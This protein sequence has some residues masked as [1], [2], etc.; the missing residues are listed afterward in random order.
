MTNWLLGLLLLTLATVAWA[1]YPH[2]QQDPASPPI[3]FWLLENAQ[4]TPVATWVPAEATPEAAPNTFHGVMTTP[5]Y[6]TRARAHNAAGYSDRS[7]PWPTPT[8]TVTPLPTSTPLRSPAPPR[9]L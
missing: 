3:D 8:R 6:G 7:N 5:Q 4:G 9:L 2:W 1:Q